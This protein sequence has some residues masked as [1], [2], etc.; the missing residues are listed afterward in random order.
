MSPF[1]LLEP[2]FLGQWVALTAI[3]SAWLYATCTSLRQQWIPG[4]AVLGLAAVG[5]AGQAFFLHGGY[6]NLSHVLFVALSSAWT[7][8][9]LRI[10]GW[11]SP[12]VIG[13]YAATAIALPATLFPVQ[14]G[15]SWDRPVWALVVNALLLRGLSVLP[16][17]AFRP[18]LL[19]PG[20]GG[21][22]RPASAAG[23]RSP[24]R[25]VRPW[26]C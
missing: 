6:T 16:L 14:T 4:S 2:Q 13:L 25:R 5:L 10:L 11:W 19:W 1:F 9:L 12:R 15:Y 22:R 24:A 21:G 18:A 26:P 8:M 20:R 23:S 3:A 7:A 17:A